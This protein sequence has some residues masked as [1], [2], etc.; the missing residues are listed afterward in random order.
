MLKVTKLVNE[1]KLEPRWSDSRACANHLS[2]YLSKV[3]ETSF[4]TI[5]GENVRS[6]ASIPSV[7]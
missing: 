7:L 1:P 6:T 2:Y 3:I 5:T 4:Q